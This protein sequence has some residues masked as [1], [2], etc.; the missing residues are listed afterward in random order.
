[1]SIKRPSGRPSERGGRRPSRTIKPETAKPRSSVVPGPG[2][3]RRI[4]KG[5][6]VGRSKKRA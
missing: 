4:E 3:D 5:W 2:P 6:D 1:M